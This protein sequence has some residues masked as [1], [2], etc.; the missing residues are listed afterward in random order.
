LDQWYRVFTPA[1]WNGQVIAAALISPLVGVAVWLVKPWSYY[2]LVGYSILLLINNLVLWMFNLSRSTFE[3]RIL[4]VA[5]IVVLVVIFL[6]KEFMAPYFNPH[7]RWW[8][9]AR[10]YLTALTGDFSMSVHDF[11]DASKLFEAGIFDISTRGC[12]IVSDR[13]VNIGQVFNFDIALP[14]GKTFH[15]TGEVVWVHPGKKDLPQGFGCRFQTVEPSFV[16]ELER[17]VKA[18]NLQMRA[19]R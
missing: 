10:R 1:L 18:L 19:E 6:R 3:M 5:G 8:E 7:L 9:Q 16:A 13:V 15:S 14:G 17:V 11:H 2:V 4:L 12:F